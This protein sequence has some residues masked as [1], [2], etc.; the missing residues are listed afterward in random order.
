MPS[1]DRAPVRSRR[2]DPYGRLV[3]FPERP[4]PRLVIA[5]AG[6]GAGKTSVTAGLLAALAARGT[7]VSPFKCGP[8]FLD[9]QLLRAAARSPS[10]SNLDCWLTSDRAFEV[11]FRR[12]GLPGARDVNVI[13][14]VMGVL[15]T[16][17]WGTSTADVAARLSAPVVLVVDA[18]RSAESVAL[19]VRGARALLPPKRLAGVIV[20]RVGGGWHSRAVRQAVERAGG[21]PVVG[22][23]P[24]SSAVTI[25]EQPLGL[26]TPQTGP[27]PGWR[28]T[29]RALGAWAAEGLEIDRILRIAR[30]APPLPAAGSPGP[31]E[32]LGVGRCLAVASDPA[33]CFL[34]PE[35]LEA[36]TDRGARIE[37]FSPVAGDRLPPSA[38]AVYLPGGFPESHA[39]AL[40][41]NEGLARELR[42]WV[43]DGRPLLAECGGMMYLLERLIGADGRSHRMAAA[44]PG[45]TRMQARLGGIGYGEARLRRNSLLG[46]RGQRLRGH[47][48]HHSR[49]KSPAGLSWAWRYW[50][51]SGAGPT[52]DGLSRGG[53]VASY[54]HLRLDE[55]PQ[56]VEA[57]LQPGP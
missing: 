7:R 54:L 11:G 16:A 2:P 39:V 19:E 24:W 8:D 25:P 51:R 53:S 48:Y 4:Y 57:M 13:E 27:G 56:V 43:D 9:P 12:H 22:M 36:F 26:R 29:L 14:G 55:Y 23:L 37:R 10:A 20:N 30:A 3:R 42:R 5:A 35:S 49:R 34:Y 46:S 18:A 31:P 6:S 1:A 44:F 40:S 15:D 52:D 32:R 45:S 21:V 50:P 47:V 38:D 17:S 33:F 28:R 41:R